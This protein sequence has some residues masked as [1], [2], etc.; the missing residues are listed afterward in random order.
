MHT[1]VVSFQS[2]TRWSR[3]TCSL[4]HI[5]THCHAHTHTHIFMRAGGVIQSMPQCLICTFHRKRTFPEAVKQN[6]IFTNKTPFPWRWPCHIDLFLRLSNKTPFLWTKLQFY[7]STLP[8]IWGMSKKDPF[9]W[10]ET[11]KKIL[12]T[13]SYVIR[14]CEMLHVWHICVTQVV[15]FHEHYDGHAS[16]SSGND[17][18]LWKEIYKRGVLTHAYVMYVCDT[19]FVWHICV[20]Q[21]VLFHLCDTYAWHRWCY[22]KYTMMNTPHQ[23]AKTWIKKSQMHLHI[24]LSALPNRCKNTSLHRVT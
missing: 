5:H 1:Q 10:K 15:L 23:K 19:L 8:H 16:C 3:L 21:V 20:T 7:D 9:L 4:S 22:F 18:F 11:H 2:R 17:I 14:S 24:I 6:P 13:H 12:F